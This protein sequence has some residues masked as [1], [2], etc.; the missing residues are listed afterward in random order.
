MYNVG[1]K[2]KAIFDKYL[3]KNTLAINKKS[4]FRGAFF[5]KKKPLVKGT[6]LAVRTTSFTCTTS[7][8]AIKV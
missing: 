7:P 4:T 3:S 6:V 5:I 2:C 1:K 8:K